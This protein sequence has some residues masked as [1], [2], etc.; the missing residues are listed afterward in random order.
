M[1]ELVKHLLDKLGGLGSEPTFKKPGMATP[2]IPEADTGGPL[3][4]SGQPVYMNG[5][6]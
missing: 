3:G 6:L 2:V 5:K 4:L 1:A